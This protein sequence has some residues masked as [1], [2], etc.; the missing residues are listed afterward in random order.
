MPN[1]RL[2]RQAWRGS[3]PQEPFAL[4]PSDWAWSKLTYGKLNAP[5][6]SSVSA[7][8]R[9]PGLVAGG[10]SPGGKC[11]HT[12]IFKGRQWRQQG[13]QKLGVPRRD[14]KSHQCAEGDPKGQAV[15]SA[16]VWH[17]QPVPLRRGS[18]C[19]TRILLPSG[20]PHLPSTLQAQARPCF[21]HPVSQSTG[22]GITPGAGMVNFSNIKEK[23]NYK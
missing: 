18:A 2:I 23:S 9:I 21:P 22:C 14:K 16:G 10:T 4:S 3:I 17:S 15:S 8:E 1:P 7:R 19:S 13:V 11:K 20:P 5:K 12:S 6:M